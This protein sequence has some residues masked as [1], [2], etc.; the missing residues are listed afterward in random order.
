MFLTQGDI[1]PAGKQLEE[2]GQASQQ[3]ELEFVVVCQVDQDRSQAR[4]QSIPNGL[5]KGGRASLNLGSFR[6][7]HVA[8]QGT[9]STGAG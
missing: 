1:E 2:P 9:L 8:C 3:R 4:L 5:S 7:I 6:H